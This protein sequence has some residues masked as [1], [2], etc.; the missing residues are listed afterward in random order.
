M[1]QR[2]QKVLA[3]AG[4]GSRR[5]VEQ[6]IREGRL[7]INGRKAQIGDALEGGEIVALDGNRLHIRAKVQPNRHILYNKPGD[8]V[9]TRSDPEGRKCVFEALPRLKGSRWVAV[10]RLD[11]TTTGL[12]L[13]TTDGALANAL[14]HPSA[15]VVRRYAVRV[16]GNPDNRQLAALKEGVELEDGPARFDAIK[17]SGGDGSNRWFEVTLKEGRNREV[18]RLWASQGFEVSRL[19]RT[20]YGPVELPRKV[21]RGKYEALTPSQV[22][23]LYTAGGLEMPSDMLRTIRKKLYKKKKLKR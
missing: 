1:S 20:A 7:S 15:G 10:G 18:R 19:I 11:M 2:V 14:M 3:A 23:L 21:R 9:T 8:E 17:A 5:Q 16:H 22:R 12:L 13:F 4:H 6:W